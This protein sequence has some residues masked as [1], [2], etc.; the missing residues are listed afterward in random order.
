MILRS[1]VLKVT[2]SGKEPKQLNPV[3]HT[4]S[5]TL[6]KEAIEALTNYQSTYSILAKDGLVTDFMVKYPECENQGPVDLDDSGLA[7]TL[8]NSFWWS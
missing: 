8:Y 6:L 4:L 1:V 5:I 2:A 7:C 3:Q